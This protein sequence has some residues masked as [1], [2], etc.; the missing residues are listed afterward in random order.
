MAVDIGRDKSTITQENGIRINF[1]R[2]G[3]CRY[4]RDQK[5]ALLASYW[6][7]IPQYR[8]SPYSRFLKSNKPTSAI[9]KLKMLLGSGMARAVATPRP[10]IPL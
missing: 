9:P 7:S 3:K 1:T 2:P 8:R 5:K 10:G 4:R 6:R